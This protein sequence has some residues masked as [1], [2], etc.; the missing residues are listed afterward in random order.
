MHQIIICL[1]VAVVVSSLN[2]CQ[3]DVGVEQGVKGTVVWL[4]GN[5]MPGPGVSLPQGEPVE[6][7]IYIYKPTTREQV[8]GQGSLF[9]AVESELVK[10]VKSDERGN[11]QARLRPG[12]YSLFVK[13]DGQYYASAMDENHYC[14]IIVED[15]AVSEVQIRIDYKAYY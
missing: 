5:Q 10:K 14:P 6:R 13:E 2:S 4:E 9:T 8:Q 11:F 3:T 15:G 12:K 1:L 7:E